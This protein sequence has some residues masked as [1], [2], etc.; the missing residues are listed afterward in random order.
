MDSSHF[1]NTILSPSLELIKNDSKMKRFYFL[2]GLISVVFLSIL[3]VYQAIYTYI[4]LLGNKDII[5]EFV[6]NLFHSNYATEII[7]WATIFI[8]FYILS[9][10]IFEWGLIRYID[11]KKS[12]EAS[13]WDSIGFWI[14]RFAP[15][16]EFNNLTAMFKFMSIVNGY[17]FA[18]R[19]LW[20]DYLWILSLIFL[21]AFFLSVILNVF[22]AYA[23]FEIV[24]AN[25]GVFEAIASSAQIALLNIK[26]TLRLYIMMFILNI[27]VII[28]FII[29]LIFP[30]LSAIILGFISSQ[31]FATILLIILGA[32]FLFLILVL[33]YLAWVLEIFTTSIWYHAYIEGKKK[34]DEASS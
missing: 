1:H 10:P 8:L 5:L 18:L 20:L 31:I 13:R 34:L 6:L 29:F 17:L 11:Q 3:L 23:K 26:T 22:I 15:V 25:K 30:I 19:F 2:P 27:K 32:I 16:F 24:L 21:I 7:I 33:G 12:W 4:E 9:V 28:N 14:Y